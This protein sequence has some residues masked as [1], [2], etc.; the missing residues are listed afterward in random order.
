[1]RLMKGGKSI[2]HVDEGVCS[3]LYF[4]LMA[5]YDTYI[6]YLFL[7]VS[8]IPTILHF[9]IAHSLSTICKNRARAAPRRTRE[10][11]VQRLSKRD[12]FFVCPPSGLN[13]A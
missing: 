10:A 11:T 9:I 4:T 8:Y 6:G 7:S 12:L 5:P 1:M 3:V 13:D 2:V